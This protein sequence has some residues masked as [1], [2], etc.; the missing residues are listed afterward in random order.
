MFKPIFFTSDLHLGHEKCLEFD[1]RPFKNLHEMHEALIK[2]FNATVPENGVTYFLGDI[3]NCTETIRKVISRLNGIKILILG[4]HDKGMVTMYNCGFD[5]VMH[6]SSFYIG[7]NLVTMS[8]CPLL[9]VKREDTKNMKAGLDENWHGESREKHRKFSYHN[10]GQFHLH[11]HIHSR[12]DKPSSQKI[13]GKQ[14]DIGVT[15][16]NYTP[17]SLSTI[18]SWIATYG[19][20]E[21]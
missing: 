6:S 7:D 3:G 2:R 19:R 12:K 18:E 16:N 20:E 11:G 8:H 14:Y 10:N 17:V 9:G 21:K 4:N 5:A 15:A 1:Q 13:L